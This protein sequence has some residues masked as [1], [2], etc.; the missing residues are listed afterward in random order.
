MKKEVRKTQVSLSDLKNLDLSMSD[1]QTQEDTTM[2]FN[3][4]H[5]KVKEAYYQMVKN[6]FLSVENTKNKICDDEKGE[7]GME[8]HLSDDVSICISHDLG[9]NYAVDL[10]FGKMQTILNGDVL[11]SIDYPFNECLY[12]DLDM[13][14]D[15]ISIKS[16]DNEIFN[17]DDFKQIS[18]GK[19]KDFDSFLKYMPSILKNDLDSQMK[20]INDMRDTFLNSVEKQKTL[21]DFENANKKNRLHYNTHNELLKKFDIDL[22]SN[23]TFDFYQI[24]SSYYLLTKTYENVHVF[25]DLFKKHSSNPYIDN[26]DSL[27]KNFELTKLEIIHH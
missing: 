15:L 12:E 19:I 17:T 21:K 26:Y 11:V 24:K 27:L 16:L 2:T 13:D 18:D 1:F 5:D 20:I 7:Y 9:I 3:N 4:Y 10:H 25:Y 6:V 23:T 14:S 22:E 8:F